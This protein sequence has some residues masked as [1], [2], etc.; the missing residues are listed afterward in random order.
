[1]EPKTVG[2]S[3]GVA[4]QANR[5]FPY[6][7][8]DCGLLSGCEVLTAE[9]L[10]PADRLAVGDHLMT[11]DSG[12]AQILTVRRQIRAVRVIAVGASSLG[13]ARPD[14]DI[15][16]AA[17]QMC[18]IRDWRARSIFGADVALVTAHSLIDGR[19]VR[20]LGVSLQE[21]TQ[22]FCDGPH[23]IYV[24]GLEIGTADAQRA[25]GSVLRAA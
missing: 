2:R 14:R 22:I 7:K 12:P 13:H 20:D 24:N 23:V 8:M 21:V 9:G 1:M 4:S 25:R 19:F 3:G 16:L 6:D 11:R 18:L 15:L 10:I 5:V 17:D